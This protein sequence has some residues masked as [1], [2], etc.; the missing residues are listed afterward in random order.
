[1]T[2]KKTVYTPE[3]KAKVA[4]VA[5]WETMTISEICSKYQIHSTQV[6]KW[7]K[8]LLERS[9]EIFEDTRK[10]DIKLIEKEKEL[11][12]LYNQLWKL[13]VENDWLKKKSVLF[14]IWN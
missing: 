4:M 5:I 12:K 9:K 11:D 3:F 1:M 10:K 14:T 13:T 6:C 8:E 2:N 7:K